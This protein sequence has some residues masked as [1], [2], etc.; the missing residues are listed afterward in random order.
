MTF[1]V[2]PQSDTSIIVEAVNYLLSNLGGTLNVDPSTGQIIGP[3]SQIVGYLYQYM[4]VKY[5]DS[6]DG[7]VNFSDSPTNRLYYG[8]RNTNEIAESSNPADYIWYQATGGFGLTKL[9]WYQTIGG[10]QISFA[11]SATAPDA[12]WQSDP[13]T[14]IDLDVVTS[15]TIPVIAETFNAYFTPA[16]LQVPRSGSPLAPVFTGIAPTMYAVDGGVVVSF[17]DA[18]TDTA[19][20]FVNGTWRIGNSST[21]GYADISYTNIT[22][23]NPSDAGDYALWPAPT[24]MPSSPAYITVPV[25][26]KNSLGVVTQ[27]GVATLQLIYT[28]P[29]AQGPQGTAGP[30]VDISGY[31]SFTQNA[32]GAFTPANAT[33]SAL[34]ENITSPTYSWAISG[35]TP[36]SSTASSVVVTPTSSSTGVTVTLTVNGSNLPSPISKTINMPVVYDGAPGT[37]G[38]NG[39]MSAFPTIYIWTGSA[40]PP[41]RPSTTSTFTWSTGAYT[42][43]SGW[44]S[45]APS[46]TTAGNYLWSITVPLNVSATTTTSVLDWTNTAY[47]IRAIAYNGTNGANGATGA[48]GAAGANGAATF[49]ITR[50]ANDSSPPTNTEVNALIGRNP[51]AGDICTVSYNNYNNAVVYRYVTSW[52]LFQTYITGSLIV[53]NTITADKLSVNQLASIS[54]STGT[55]VVDNTG[56]IRG[57]QTNYNTGTGFFLGYSGASYKFSIGNSTVNMLWDGSAMTVN[58]AVIQTGTTGA[59]LVMGGPSYNHALIGYN[60]SGGQTMAFNASTGQIYASNYTSLGS[61]GDFDNTSASPA[62][63]GSNTGFNNGGGVLGNSTSGFGGEFYGN[64]NRGTVYIDPLPSL[65]TNV[66]QGGLAVYNN[67]LYFCNG[68][69]W[70]QVQLI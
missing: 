42:A 18:Q 47:P 64:T 28:D 21:T 38:A 15:G 59:R 14:A 63:R 10:R 43:P 67:N 40:T 32:G 33:L 45:Q 56:Y 49:V 26:Y 36:T 6:A 53:Q 31:A 46:N 5:A 48:T 60:S 3:N 34:I 35:A 54:S 2:A 44:S 58:G 52:T 19:A 41:T 65:P 57:G 37:A 17:V 66:I 61:A 7:S 50:V 22:V 51:V 25:R 55:L 12:G 4:A 8:L 30:T 62:L 11:V 1:A 24:A 39:V 29:G 9:L 70:K 68:T 13:S 69:T 20:N 16:I 27:A 23:G